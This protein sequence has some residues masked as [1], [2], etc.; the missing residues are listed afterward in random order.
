[1]ESPADLVGYGDDIFLCR[2]PVRIVGMKLTATMTVVRLP[3]RQLLLYSP[4]HL[5][6]E[7]RRA[8]ESLGTV[9]E[10][11][12]PNTFHHRW[13]GEWSRAFP[14]ARVH[15]P[16]ALREKRSDLTVRRVSDREPLGSLSSV[17]EEVSI[18]GFALHESV[19]LH[20]PSGTLLVADLVHNIGK[21]NDFWTRAY[22]KTMGFYD[23]VAISKMI[24][25]T[26][27]TDARAAR[28]SLDSL[29]SLDFDRLVVGHGS[30]VSGGAR[31]L[32][33]DAYRWLHPKS[34]QLALRREAPRR[35]LCG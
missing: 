2:D 34:T 11:Y 23:R 12:A 25:W 28:H 8:I 3:N 4:V 19:L 14:E 29:F 21:P 33:I 30:P 13:I 9:A 20:R 5:T 15:A 7:R 32:L 24:R 17:F 27:F 31:Q 26:A 6:E 35:G 16:K 22:S 10:L 1:M 18:G